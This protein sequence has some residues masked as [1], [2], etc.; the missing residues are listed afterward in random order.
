MSKRRTDDVLAAVDGIARAEVIKRVKSYDDLVTTIRALLPYAESRA[1]DMSSDPQICRD[2]GMSEESVADS[3]QL[4]DKANKAVDGAKGLLVVA[5]AE[6]EAVD[7]GTLRDLLLLVGRE[8]P[9][10]HFDA[11]SERDRRAVEKWAIACHLRASDCGV[12]VPREPEVT[13]VL[14]EV[15]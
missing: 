9:R 15:A 11:W 2:A 6:D 3:E 5:G 13:Q 8:L 4:A 10:G 14:P 1:E 7:F 12:R